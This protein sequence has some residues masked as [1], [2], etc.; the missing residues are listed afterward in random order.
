MPSPRKRPVPRLIAVAGGKGGVGK[1]TVAANLAVALARVGQRVTLVDADLGAAN[2]H[3]MLGLVNPAMGIAEFL[4]QRTD[5]LDAVR[6]QILLPTL[7]IV[8]GTSRPGAANLAKAQKLRLLNAL[9]RVDADVVVIDV[10]AGS[11]YNVV[12]L[13]SAADHKFLVMTPQ[14]P[15]L[16]NA[17]ALLKGCVHRVARRLALDDIQQSLVDAALGNETKARTITQLLAVLRPLD[18]SFAARISDTLL[19][20]GVAII[21]N[22]IE[23]AADA[24]A[25]TRMSPLIYDHLMT[26]APVIAT[27]KRSAT[28][29][30]GLRAG[31]GV[32]AN[33]DESAAAFRK[34]AQAILQ[35]DLNQLRGLERVTTQSTQPLWVQRDAMIDEEAAQDGEP[36]AHHK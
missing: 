18:A 16:H 21:A 24:G 25:L 1:S 4:D 30:G 28:L 9:A 34:L 35:I 32:L 12:D 33:N 13:V 22:Q 7:F 19:H 26:P 17:Y 31:A 20:F 36:A 11:S 3:T 6:V 14:L 23:H 27:I 15:S 10:G 29:A 5:S 2:L 8:A